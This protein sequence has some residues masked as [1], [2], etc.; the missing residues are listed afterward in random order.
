MSV[1][2]FFSPDRLVQNLAFLLG[3]DSSQIRLV[4]VVTETIS[5]RRRRQ[6][7]G[8]DQQRMQVD[9]EFEI[10]NP[11]V[12]V[13][14]D[15]TNMTSSDNKTMTNDTTTE[16]P[17]TDS[18]LS[19]DKLEDLT[20]M[21]VDVIQT[22][23]LTSELNAT[24]VNAVVM[25][26]EPEPVDPTNG[27][28]ATPST[29][30]PQPG[31]NGTE[32]LDTFSDMQ[33]RMEMEERNQTQQVVFTIPTQLSIERSFRAMETEGIPLPQP[34]I[35]VM[36]DNFNNIIQNLG[37]DEAWRVRANVE[38]SPQGAFLA[39]DTAELV[40]GRAEFSGLAFSYPG[41]YQIS[42]EVVF[43]ESAEFRVVVEEEIVVLPRDLQLV[44]ASQPSNGNTTHPFYPPPVVELWED[45]ALLRDHDWR[46]SIWWV[47]ATL[48]QG[49]RSLES[50]VQQLNSGYAEFTEIAY[51][52]PGEFTL[53]FEVFT[54]PSSSHVPATATSNSFYITRHPLTRLLITYDEDYDS[55]IG[56]ND[57][58][59]QQFITTFTAAFLDTFPSQTVEIYNIT[60]ARGSIVVSVFLTSRS[61]RDL[62]N[63]VETVIAANDTFNF[64]FRGVNLVPLIT[65][66][67]AYPVSL[68]EE[69]EDE[70]TL[71]L[72]TI[73]PSGTVLLTTLLIILIVTLCYRHR[74]NTQSFKVSERH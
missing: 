71:I 4:S 67:P 39:N 9:V 55:I 28:R 72:V 70:L 74:K 15:T 26:P 63:Y 22:G 73:I 21:V 50:W 23:Q 1:D 25:E 18:T 3:I 11:P 48:T 29:G 58:L 6:D 40:S 17:P 16:A 38:S 66:D 62:L 7:G 20:E 44:I 69:E 8:T 65:Q 12:I 46:N 24:V 19:F 34:P 36:F 42:F 41:T 30:G 52:Y 10:G 32:L 57:E 43:P 13:T 37:L 56:E 54:E 33:F 5:K 64:M 31:E 61:A 14:M 49:G 68:P 51:R 59:L 53:V 47:R 45:G 2:D 60:A 27:N 35:L